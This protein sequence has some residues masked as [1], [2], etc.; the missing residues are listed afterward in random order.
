MYAPFVYTYVYN[1][2]STFLGAAAFIKIKILFLIFSNLFFMRTLQ[3]IE[4]LSNLSEFKGGKRAYGLVKMGSPEL[5]TFFFTTRVTN[6][7]RIA[8]TKTMEY[9]NASGDTICVEW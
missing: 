7:K 3:S 5:T 2:R 6:A 4:K 8:G 1:R 9:T